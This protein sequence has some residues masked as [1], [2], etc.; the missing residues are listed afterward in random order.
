MSM[1][2]FLTC[3]EGNTIKTFIC[4]DCVSRYGIKPKYPADS[5]NKSWMCKKCGHFNIGSQMK[6]KVGDL[7]ELIPLPTNAKLT[8]PHDEG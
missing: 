4:N 6:C 1:K 5:G 7:L 3:E 2:D 8:G